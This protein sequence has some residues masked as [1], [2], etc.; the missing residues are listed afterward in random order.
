MKFRVGPK[1]DA[2]I[3]GCGHLCSDQ[4]RDASCC[5]CEFLQSEGEFSQTFCFCWICAMRI[6]RDLTKATK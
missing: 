2:E 5:S 4:N 1:G 6:W 3:K